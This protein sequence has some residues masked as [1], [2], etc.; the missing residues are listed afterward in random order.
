MWHSIVVCDI[1]I[2]ILGPTRPTT[3]VGREEAFVERSEHWVK[4]R[5]PPLTG[6]LRLTREKTSPKRPLA[7]PE[8]GEIDWIRQR[9]RI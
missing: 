7:R 4:R 3:E 8:N 5:L 2:L 6:Q 9:F 1:P